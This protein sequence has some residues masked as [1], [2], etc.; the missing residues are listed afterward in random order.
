VEIP[1]VSSS[2]VL[3]RLSI[4]HPFYY[5]T[6]NITQPLPAALHLGTHHLPTEAQ[7]QHYLQGTYTP[8]VTAKKERKHSP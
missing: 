1:A 4:P 5:L 7:F 6:P 2:S 3:A 8:R